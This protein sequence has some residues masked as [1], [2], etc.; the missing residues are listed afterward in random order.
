VNRGDRGLVE[1]GGRV[2]FEGRRLHRGREW[3]RRSSSSKVWWALTKPGGLTGWWSTKLETIPAV[4]GA[5][6]HWT[7]GGDF[8]PVMQMGPWTG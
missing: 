6:L 1:F 5:K 8:N 7:F 3:Q 2:R 4:V